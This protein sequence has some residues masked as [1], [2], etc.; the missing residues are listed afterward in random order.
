M[1]EALLWFVGNRNPS[2][3][4]NLVYADGTPVDLSASTVKFKMRGVGVDTLKVDAAA[5]IVAPPTAGNVRYDWAA[6]DV[7]TEGYYLVWWEVTTTGKTQDLAEALIEFRAHSEAGTQSYVELE[8]FKSSLELTGT[9][10]GDAD[11]QRALVAAS[12]SLERTFG[13]RWYTTTSNEVRYYTPDDS[14]FLYSDEIVA[15]TE[16]ATDDSGGTSFATLWTLNT[17]Y[18]LEPLNANLDGEPWRKITALPTSSNYFRPY[19]PR[20]VRL[21]GRF[22]W[23]TTPSG[24]QQATEI[25][26]SQV[27]KRIR[28]A[29]FGIVNFGGEAL[30]LSRYDS[31]VERAMAPYN[32]SV[33]VA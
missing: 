2:I 17:D 3:T 28:E 25:I 7:D 9:T 4:E 5:V 12:R 6:L 33:G 20:S 14:C 21:T 27:L 32:R 1:S 16:L 11:I 8:E 30:R 26:A 10:Y 13:S 22:G 24:V 31:D 29:P 15:L 23:S 18:V 19:Y